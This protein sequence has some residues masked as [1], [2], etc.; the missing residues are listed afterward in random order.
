MRNENISKYHSGILQQ[1]SWRAKRL[2]TGYDKPLAKIE[3]FT[4]S[5]SYGMPEWG[6]DY[7]TEEPLPF[8]NLASQKKIY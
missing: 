4:E 1:H 3:G 5:L 2:W 7:K 8:M 6:Y